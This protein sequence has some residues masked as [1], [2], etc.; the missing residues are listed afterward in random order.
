M[1][2]NSIPKKI[3][4]AIGEKTKDLLEVGFEI[5]FDYPELLRGTSLYRDDSLNP[6]M[7]YK[8]VSNLKRHGYL[9]VKKIEDKKKLYLTPKGR[10]EIIK[11]ILKQKNGKELKWDGKWRAIIFDV[12]EVS[13]RDRD[14]LRRELSWIGFKELQ[15]SVWIFPYEVEKELKALLQ[16]WKLDFTGDIRF[17]TIV[18]IEND[19]DLRKCFNLS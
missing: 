8:G 19:E 7:F 6:P 18:K 2:R 1:K 5:V 16:F 4:L 15:K 14:F 9:K 10:V 11:S 12:P 3:L 13:R 17:L